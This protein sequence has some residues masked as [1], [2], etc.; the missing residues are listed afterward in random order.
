[1]GLSK[2]NMIILFTKSSGD[3]FIALL[4]YIDDIVITGNNVIEIENVKSFMSSK[5]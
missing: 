4:V 5:F 2:V 1:M 3:V